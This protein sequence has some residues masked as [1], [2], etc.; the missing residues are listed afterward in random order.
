MWG[1]LDKVF[2]VRRA[3]EKVLLACI[4]RRWMG[5]RWSSM[6]WFFVQRKVENT[7]RSKAGGGKE[8]VAWGLYDHNYVN[9]HLFI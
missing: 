5:S 7:W 6:V 4:V 8:E 1:L 2:R 3:V 9:S